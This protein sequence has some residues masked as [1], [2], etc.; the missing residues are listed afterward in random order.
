MMAPGLALETHQIADRYLAERH[1]RELKASAIEPSMARHCCF[2]LDG[3]AAIER[4]LQGRDTAELTQ[5]TWEDAQWR[6]LRKKQ[7]ISHLCEYGGLFFESADPFTGKPKD[8][9]RVKP[10]HP[11]QGS[12]GK[13]V[14]YE[15]LQG[16]DAELF[17]PKVT[18]ACGY[19][20]AQ[21][22]G[23]E[24]PYEHRM[25][26]AYEAYRGD[27]SDEWGATGTGFGEVAQS[28][29]RAQKLGNGVV[30]IARELGVDPDFLNTED[31][32]FWPW[33][34]DTPQLPL[35]LEEGE[36]KAMCLA[37][38]GYAA[39]SA[40]G[41]Y[42]FVVSET[43]ERTG[44]KKF[45]LHPELTPFA[46]KDRQFVI[47]FDRDKKMK[48]IRSVAHAT[49]RTARLLEKQGCEVRVAL[50]D[51]ERGKGVDDF[52]ANGGDFDRAFERA[53]PSI[54][55]TTRHYWSLGDYRVAKEFNS[56]FFPSD[57]EIPE[58][59]Q[60]VCLKAAKGTG[61]TTWIAQQIAAIND[62][63][64]YGHGRPMQVIVLSHRRQL[65]KSL[66][67]GLKLPYVTELRDG[68]GSLYGFSLC[69]DSAHAQSQAR[70]N[71]DNYHDAIVVFDE[72]EQQLAHLFMANT[73][74]AKHRVTVMRNISTLLEN[75]FAS[76]HGMVFAA[77]AD[78]SHV[79]LDWM[80]DVSGARRS[81]YPWIARNTWKNTQRKCYLYT[82]SDPSNWLYQYDKELRE[83]GKV[84]ANVSGQ[85]ASS[86]WG[87]QSL[88]T[89][90]NREFPEKVTDRIDAD[91]TADPS[92]PAFNCVA[93]KEKIDSIIEGTD[94]LLTSPVVET[95][96][97]FDRKGIFTANF[98]LAWGQQPTNS[99][100]QGMMRLRDTEADRHLWVP[101]VASL[102]RIGRHS[103][104]SHKYFK[105]I[106]QKKFNFAFDLLQKSA[107]DRTT[108]KAIEK[109]DLEVRDSIGAMEPSVTAFSKIVA[110]TNAGFVA[111]R[112]TLRYELEEEGYTVE[113]FEGTP[114]ED[115]MSEILEK[116]RSARDDNQ[117]AEV[118][119]ICSAELIPEHKYEPLKRANSRSPEARYQIA[120]YELAEKYATPEITPELIE[121]DRDGWHGQLKKHYQLTR[122]REFVESG[123]EAKLMK[124][125]ANQG[126]FWI[127]DVNRR[128]K[129]FSVKGM[130]FLG[131]RAL[132]EAI[133]SEPER[134][135]TGDEPELSHL[136]E[137]IEKFPEAREIVSVHG[138]NQHGLSPIAVANSILKEMGLKLG[139]S[140]RT[141]IEGKTIRLYKLATEDEDGNAIGLADG[142]AD[143]F[144]RWCD[145]DAREQTQADKDLDR[146]W[147]NRAKAEAAN[148]TD[149][150]LTNSQVEEAASIPARTPETP[151]SQGAEGCDRTCYINRSINNAVLTQ[152]PVTVFGSEGEAIAATKWE[153][154]EPENRKEAIATNATQPTNETI[155]AQPTQWTGLTG[156]IADGVKASGHWA[157]ELLSLRD[158]RLE[159]LSEP[160]YSDF[161]GWLVKVRPE[162]GEARSIRC[163]WFVADSPPA[164]AAE[165]E[166]LREMLEIADT[167]EELEAIR[168]AAPV[169]WLRAAF[170]RLDEFAQ[171][172]IRQLQEQSEINE[173]REMF[174][175]AASAADTTEGVEAVEA[176]RRVAPRETLRAAFVRLDEF[177]QERIRQLQQQSEID[178]LREMLEIADTVEAVE[179]LRRVAPREILRAAFVALEREA[180]QRI[181][182][183]QQQSEIEELREMLEIA[184]TVEAVEALRRI[185]PRE[186]L[187]AVFVRLDEM[188][189]ERIRQLQEQSEINEL[190]ERLE[191]ADTV[192]AVEAL[193]R[194][195]PR[196]VLR[197]AFVALEREAQQRIQQLRAMA[198]GFL[199]A[200]SPETPLAASDRPPARSGEIDELR[201]MLEIAS[202]ATDTTE[203]VEAVE[204]LRSLAPRAVLRAAFT[205]LDEMAQQRI[206]QLR[207]MALAAAET[208]AT[209]VEPCTT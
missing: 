89:Y 90:F 188:A 3:D 162:D 7:Q 120:K 66:G 189:Q 122:G 141:R 204:A 18:W 21:K 19:R 182:Q 206:R 81:I 26:E 175:I 72:I 146:I 102:G 71:P 10:N 167:V 129:S 110:R 151:S 63:Y 38:H 86:Q 153:P 27:R 156:R 184:D 64:E 201:E 93:E 187:R 70:F 172:R 152:T 92:H 135:W 173:L 147:A 176:L 171:Q 49:E 28:L 97:S 199:P 47:A 105:A 161:E 202:S 8:F 160:W 116:F 159:F 87:T 17:F 46:I 191:V 123:D 59:E 137:Q 200:Q 39:I 185:A 22:H 30:G 163:E 111:Y 20:I 115:E 149:N 168:L 14:K 25:R 98:A 45:Q 83:G 136:V 55:A 36:K 124:M 128:C 194:I 208:V 205:Q 107:A 178:E 157:Y 12:D 150:V 23:L 43:N 99:V 29:D 126:G 82:E 195:A 60:F 85:K 41:I 181:R 207:A 138:R 37:S 203:G 119:A 94:H 40:P 5:R 44:R 6:A 118:Q 169:E 166:E 109:F 57:L 88:E 48:T 117:K 52:I 77:D 158:K 190:R 104:T 108:Q 133:E 11:R 198:T 186:I 183:L 91:T 134:I 114:D 125:W 61:K 78:L 192:E 154:T 170:V 131:V 76:E 31:T 80:L 74:I 24:E 62:K 193:R 103:K 155:S 35:A 143:V 132:L 112:E 180:Q 179:A 197:A 58:G 73:E 144:E 16:A 54:V 69:L 145:R 177:A 50:W 164:R 2:S 1:W 9:V 67:L 100:R 130:E 79:S 140:S 75:V 84:F 33:T 196:K 127:W 165:I 53:V 68:E 4:F 34:L 139:C 95:G 65:A 142:R 13:L 148:R 101:K 42:M 96:L 209:E 106:E 121:R 174:E 56:E 32:G 113:D 51:G 15:S